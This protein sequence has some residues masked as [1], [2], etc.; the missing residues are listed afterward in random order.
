M[1]IC[2]PEMITLI[3]IKSS[4]KVGIAFQYSG[5]HRIKYCNFRT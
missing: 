2:M 3:F 5:P 4:M 1:L